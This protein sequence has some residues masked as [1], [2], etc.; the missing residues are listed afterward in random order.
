MVQKQAMKTMYHALEVTQFPIFYLQDWI[1]FAQVLLLDIP[2]NI[3]KVVMYP[4]MLAFTSAWQRHL[5]LLFL[6]TP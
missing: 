3:S 2:K 5:N 6:S 4:Y 1:Y